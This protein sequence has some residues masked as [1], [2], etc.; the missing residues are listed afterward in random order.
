[1]LESLSQRV[2]KLAA[3][4]QSGV[5]VPS[6]SAESAGRPQSR[7]EKYDHQVTRLREVISTLVP[8]GAAV[9]VVSKG[10]ARLV[11]LDGRVGL[12][13]PQ[14][15]SGGYAGHYPADTADLLQRLTAMRQRGSSHFVIPA[16]GSWWLSHYQGLQDYLSKQ[17]EILFD[18]E[19]VGKV[20]R[21]VANISD[22]RVANVPP[23]HDQQRVPQK[24]RAARKSSDARE[25]RLIAFYLPQFHP[26]PENDRSWGAG[27]TEWTNVVRAKPAFA[28]H[29][30]PQ[31]PGELGFYDLRT[32]QTREAQAALAK[33]HGIFGFCYYHYWFA[34]KRLLEQPFEEVLRTGRPDF[35]FCLCWANEPWSRRW[36]GGNKEV[37]QAQSYSPEDDKAH[38][39]ALLPALSDPRAIKVDGK[40]VFLIYR[41]KDL[42]DPARTINTWRRRVRRAGLRGVYLIAVETSWDTNWD[43]TRVGFDAKVVFQPQWGRLEKIPSRK[44]PE[45]P[46]L[47]VYNY[48]QAWPALAAEPQESAYERFP[49]V[50]PGWDNSARVADKAVILHGATPALY[51]Q[52]LD[53][54]IDSVQ[55]RPKDRRLVFINAW[56]EWAEGTHLEPDDRFGRGFLQ[57]TRNA[58]RGEPTSQLAASKATSGATSAAADNSGFAKDTVKQAFD[59]KFYWSNYPETI[60]ACQDPLDHYLTTGWKQGLKPNPKF[61]P[62]FYLATHADV[63]AAGTEPLTH[64]VTIG[65]KEGRVGSRDDVRIEPFEGRLKIPREAVRRAEPVDESIRAI[66]FYLPQFHAIPENDKWWGKG[67]TEWTNVRRGT[68]QFAGH[69]QPHVPGELGYYDLSDRQVMLRQIELARTHGIYGFCFYYYWFAGKVLLDLP[70]R[71]LTSE[72]G[73][74]FPFCICWANENWSRRWDGRENEVLIAQHHSAED[75]IAFIKKVEPLLRHRNYIRIKGRPLLLVYRPALLPDAKATAERWREYLRKA[76]HGEV[77]LAMTHT[78]QAHKPASDYGFDIAIQFPPHAKTTPVTP[79]IEGRKADFDGIVYDY[80]QTKRA[81]LRELLGL[82]SG[83][84]LLPGVM[85]SWDNTARRREHG[86]IWIN[87]SPESYCDWLS[88]TTAFLRQQRPSEERLV[89]INAWNEWAEG[90]H[91]EPDK[92]FGRAWLNATRIALRKPELAAAESASGSLAEKIVS[93]TAAVTVAP[94]A[95]HRPAPLRVAFVSHDAYPHGAQYCVLNLARWLKDAGLVEPRFLLAGPGPLAEEFAR[96]GP[97]LALD[98]VLKD[99]NSTPIAADDAAVATLRSFCGPHLQAVYVNSAAAAHVCDITR[100]LAVRHIAHVHELQESIR[101]WVGSAKMRL[102]EKTAHLFIAASIP[103]SQ[104]LKDNHRIAPE[105][106]RVVHESI[107]CTGI[108]RPSS[109]EKRNLRR[110]LGIPT[111]GKMFL[112]CGTTDARKGPDLFVEV[113]ARVN[114]QASTPCHFIWVGTQT[115]PGEREALTAKSRKLNVSEVVSF[116]DAVA[117]PLPYMLAADVF[118]LPSREDPF[119]LVCL[120][121]A[122]CG[123]PIACFEDAGGMP[124]F[125]QDDCGVLSPYL[126]VEHMARRLLWMVENEKHLLQLGRR[127]QQKVRQTYD[128][129]VKGPLIAD[130]IREAV[131]RGIG[132]ESRKRRNQRP[133]LQKAGA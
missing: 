86:S 132:G 61:D 127:A 76:G 31:L 77:V 3:A 80:E 131:D 83:A 40:P 104:N 38:I 124:E 70:I 60:L 62:S 21:F 73:A 51:R 39:E 105:R 49:C 37:I 64:F 120:E 47:R 46:N 9:A 4:I 126:N 71:T 34:G 99:A 112:G 57:E 26:I 113:A 13:F 111:D 23:R 30:Q 100:H 81:Y 41:A 48:E 54:A 20:Y 129:S 55:D 121:A 72:R 103:V 118:V 114:R 94:T 128:V 68:P 15:E 91:L 32:P 102:L 27:F 16:S 123:L 63:A 93:T 85:P 24:A 107:R 79:L 133:V 29:Y 117:T 33:E 115:K 44:V 45:K 10:D 25:V 78:F 18:E 90:C 11:E 52:W 110:W 84:G 95:T 98:R 75:D 56:N 87:C 101:R 22:P 74:D 1:L 8:Q 65:L 19:E 2:E 28:G 119:P 125:V 82:K 50:A 116:R 69:Y 5:R 7:A 6:A 66:A 96:I 43:A 106:I 108:R 97:V 12:H 122:D 109:E 130:V 42:P 35:P 36:D 14:S 88:T 89:F 53:D 67:F 17:A 58:V 92:K 59:A